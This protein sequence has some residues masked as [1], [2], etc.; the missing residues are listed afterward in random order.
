MTLLELKTNFHKLIDEIN[1]DEVL[2]Q[3]YE[4]LSSTRDRQEGMLWNKLSNTEHKELV[5]T[6]KLS[7]RDENLLSHDEMKLKN[8]KWL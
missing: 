2:N 1:N 8:K 5:E 6:E 4:I 7:H 3:F